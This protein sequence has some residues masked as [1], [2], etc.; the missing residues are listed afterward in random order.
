MS[1]GFFITKTG[2][3]F[4]HMS[5]RISK[6]IYDYCLTLY[7]LLSYVNLKICILFG[8]DSKF[9][10][11]FYVKKN[12]NSDTRRRA[13]HAPTGAA[14]YGCSY[15]EFVS[16][17]DTTYISTYRIYF[18]L[19]TSCIPPPDVGFSRCVEDLQLFSLTYSYF[20]SH[21]YFVSLI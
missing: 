16:W 9:Y 4:F 13:Y 10:I 20:H 5:R 21:F 6:T 8:Y 15:T 11:E 2:V 3:C 1:Y 19:G 14:V 7:T 12:K 17:M 18:M